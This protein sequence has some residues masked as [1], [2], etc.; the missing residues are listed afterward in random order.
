MSDF[1]H[2]EI[3][4][5]PLDIAGRPTVGWVSFCKDACVANGKPRAIMVKRNGRL[6]IYPVTVV[7]KDKAEA[8]EFAQ[9]RSKR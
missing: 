8:L 1:E 9:K 5:V 2:E 6:E 4:Y 3:L 7:F